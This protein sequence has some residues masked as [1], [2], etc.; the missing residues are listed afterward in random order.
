MSTPEQAAAAASRA[1][2]RQI[3]LGILGFGEIGHGLALGLRE[4]GLAEIA[5]Y[6]RNPDRPLVRERVASS[7]VRLVQTPAELAEAA[8][9]IIAVTQGAATI[10]AGRAIAPALCERHL[11]VDLASA[12]PKDKLSVAT[13]VIPQGATFADGAIE[14]STLEHGH[15]VPMIVSGPGAAAFAD[16]M[17]PW[18]M[19]IALVGPE[20]G[21]AS[22]IKTL[23]HVVQKG[24]MALLIECTVAARKYGL[25]DEVLASIAEWYDALPFMDNATRVL[26]TTT[27]HAQRRADEARSALEILQDLD[28][29]PIMSRATVEL[30]TK[31]ADLG[32]REQLGGVV[33]K[34]HGE[35]IE[36]MGK[37]YR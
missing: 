3:R 14:G 27:I 19:R 26:R 18:G 7:G 6:Q 32:L 20:T 15:A 2:R 31:V 25:T 21:K 36:L 4:A 17:T 28:I 11:Y 12:S 1:S 8:D 16:L 30:L 10:D 33:P 5:A 35:A 29:D 34:T 22:A 9:L 13:L 23:R 37:Y 24:I